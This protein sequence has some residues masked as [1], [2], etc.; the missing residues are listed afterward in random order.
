MIGFPVVSLLTAWRFIVEPS[1]NVTRFSEAEI[2]VSLNL[3]FSL[4]ENPKYSMVSL[5]ASQSV[6]ISFPSPLV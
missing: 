6:I 3:V 4:S 2:T 1:L 5:T